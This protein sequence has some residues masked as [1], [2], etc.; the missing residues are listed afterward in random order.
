MVLLSSITY[1]GPTAYAC[2]NHWRTV[3][4]AQFELEWRQHRYPVKVYK[5]QGE[6]RLMYRQAKQYTRY[7]PFAIQISPH[8]PN[9]LYIYNVHKTPKHS[10][11]SLVNLMLAIGRK[12]RASKA[13]L[14]DAAHVICPAN[15]TEMHLSTLQLIKHGRGYYENFGFVPVGKTKYIR[16]KQTITQFKKIKLGAV[17]RKFEQAV[18]LLSE[19]RKDPKKFDLQIINTY[20]YPAQYKHEP[21]TQIPEYL[22]KYRKFVKKMKASKSEYLYQFLSYSAAHATDCALYTDFVEMANDRYTLTYKQKKLVVNK[23]SET[24]YKIEQLYPDMLEYI[25][26]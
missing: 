7:I 6:W 11:A 16:A 12:V 17:I 14:Q 4:G 10:G 23:W 2:L 21:G 8:S 19:A 26:Q 22:E 1:K 25:Y 3:Y 9:E 5:Y 18:Q 13:T 15:Q 24:L 20:G